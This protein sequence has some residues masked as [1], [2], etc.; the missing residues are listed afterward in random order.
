MNVLNGFVYKVNEFVEYCNEF[1]NID[2]GIYPIASKKV[3]E[4]AVVKYLTNPHT[5]TIEFDSIDREMVR[6]II[7]SEYQF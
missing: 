4:E 3:I 5:T 7:Q 6:S 2:Y 1:Y